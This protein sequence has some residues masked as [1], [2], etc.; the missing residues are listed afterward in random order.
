MGKPYWINKTPGLL[1]HL[2]RLP[3]LYP[4]AKCIHVLRD[5]RDVAA[6]N[7]SLS[8]GPT[9]VRDAARRWK[10]LILD[11]R[12]GVDPKQLSYMELHYEELI[13]F[14]R[15]VL[16]NV[17][18]FMGLDA[19]PGEVLSRIPVFNGR[20]EVWRSVFS[21]EDRRTFAKEAGDLLLELGYEKDHSWVG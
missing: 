21:Q 4:K 15:E 19:D 7:L 8:W 3:K 17:F 2:Q 13:K 5:G 14:P 9:N 6:S 18:A 16:K 20:I 12:R 10:K 1:T 11:G